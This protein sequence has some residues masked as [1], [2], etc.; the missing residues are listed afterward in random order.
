M[1][2]FLFK[3]RG[4]VHWKRWFL[5]SKWW[6]F[7]VKLGLMTASGQFSMVESWFPLSQNPDFLFRDPDFRLKNVD[8]IIYTGLAPDIVWLNGRPSLHEDSVQ[9][10]VKLTRSLNQKWGILYQKRGTLDYKWW[11]L[12]VCARWIW[13]ARTLG[14][15]ERWEGG[16]EYSIKNH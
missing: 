14:G 15:G 9:W 6:T 13:Q 11:I 2:D 4:T 5:Y 8:F 10:W 3:R 1:M 16:D 12:Q 7:Q